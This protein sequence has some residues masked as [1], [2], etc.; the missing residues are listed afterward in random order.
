MNYNE[1]VSAIHPELEAPL[2]K[3][4]EYHRLSRM[5]PENRNF[6]DSASWLID[7]Y[8]NP[9]KF[10]MQEESEYESRIP[11]LLA[12]RR[13]SA[14]YRVGDSAIVSRS[15]F[16]ESFRKLT[17][18]CLDGMF[19]LVFGSSVRFVAHLISRI[20]LHIFYLRRTRLDKY[21]R[22]RRFHPRM[23]PPESHWIS[24]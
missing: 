9:D 14:G 3:E 24:A 2:E 18:G 21:L 1:L 12:Q 4:R 6:Y 7:V 20:F 22:R 16:D 15:Q 17:S 11:K 13:E 23:S 10:I 8:A 19:L 5:S